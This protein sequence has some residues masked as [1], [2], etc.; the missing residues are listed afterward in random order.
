M[1]GCCVATVSETN[2]CVRTS[3]EILVHHFDSNPMNATTLKYFF[4]AC[5]CER[6]CVAAVSDIY[7]YMIVGILLAWA[8]VR[9]IYVSVML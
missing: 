6:G 1:N 9:A 3:L 2:T 5:V 4:V 7:K 8:S